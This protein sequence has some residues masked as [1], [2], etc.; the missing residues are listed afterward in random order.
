MRVRKTLTEPPEVLVVKMV[1]NET[2]HNDIRLAE[3]RGAEKIARHPRNGFRQTRRARLEVESSHA[4]VR[5]RPG[6]TRAE[7]ALSRAEFVNGR[8]WIDLSPSEFPNDP[9]RPAEQPIQPPQV[10][11]TPHGVRIGRIETVENF[12]HKDSMH[13]TPIL[14]T[15]PPKVKRK[16]SQ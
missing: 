12:R 5:E 6:Q 10:A 7:P 11:P 15:L 8:R 13:F 4:R 16:S 3:S 1:Q 14:P 2:P 9:T